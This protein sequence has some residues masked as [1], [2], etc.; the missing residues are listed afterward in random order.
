MK[1]KFFTLGLFAFLLLTSVNAHALT[2]Y[3]DTFTPPSPNTLLANQWTVFNFKSAS[4][5][6]TNALL[7]LNIT[8]LV[9]A[10]TTIGRFTLTSPPSA[11]VF[12]ESSYVATSDLKLGLNTFNLS[13]YLANNTAGINVGLLV[14][15]GSITFNSARLTGTVAPEPASIALVCAGLVGLPFARR[16]R[17]MLGSAA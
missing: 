10:K 2:N 16:L 6:L 14:D 12:T 8:D 17:K 4:G 7:T 11:E 15:R 9:N 5:P 3:D 13:N 1:T